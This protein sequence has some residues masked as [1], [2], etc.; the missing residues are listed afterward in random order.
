LEGEV[1]IRPS[2]AKQ[3]SHRIKRG[4]NAKPLQILLVRGIESGHFDSV[5]VQFSQRK[6][7][8]RDPSRHVVK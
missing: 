6:A 5:D 3:P 7:T 4:L 2:S 8:R 1:D